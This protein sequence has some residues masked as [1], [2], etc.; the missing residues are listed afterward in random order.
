MKTL[1]R[2]IAVLLMFSAAA[3][4]QQALREVMAYYYEQGE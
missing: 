4:G 2:V 1:R 3:L